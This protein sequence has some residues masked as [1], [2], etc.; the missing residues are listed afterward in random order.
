M[1]SELDPSQNNQRL[2]ALD[3]DLPLLA[4]EAAIDIEN[5]LSNRSQDYT[6]IRNLANRLRNSISIDTSD[7]PPHSLMDSA[8]LTVLGQAVAEAMR[9]GTLQR[10]DD[11]LSEAAKI[12]KSLSSETPIEN[13]DELK[14]ARDFCVALS[15]A[16]MAYHKSIR[17]LHP[18]HPFRR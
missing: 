1:L 11:L 9:S 8:T 4:S 7:N 3:P 16:V 5:I 2:R 14:Q 18:S 17:D 12:A 13:P 10:V 6:A 15:R